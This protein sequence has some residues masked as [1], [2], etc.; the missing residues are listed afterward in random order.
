[1]TDTPLVL[2]A[3][4]PDA[5]HEQ[6]LALV[7]KTLKGKPFDK[8]MVDRTPEGIAIPGLHSKE[9]WDA[10]GDP[11]GLPGA[12]PF[13]RGGR[14]SG[15]AA[16]GWDI[17]Q[18]CAHPNPVTANKQ[19]LA[20]LETGATSV[21]LRLDLAGRTGLDSDAEGPLAGEDG[22]MVSS[23]EDL[24]T[25]LTG[26]YLDG[27]TVALEAGGGF[28]G[29]AAL[30][31]ALWRNK[32]IAPSAA[33]GAFNADPL[34]SL[35]LLGALPMTVD[36]ALERMAALAAH[37]AATYPQVTAVMVDTGAHHGAGATE[38]ED[39]A[40]MLATGVAYL[41]AMEQTGMDLGTAARQIVF[42]LPLDADQFPAIAKLRAARLL[43]G[44]VCAACGIEGADA[45]MRLTAY[46]S[47]R[48]LTRRDPWVNMLRT[49]VTCFAAAVGGADAV[50]TTP[51]DAALGVPTDFARRVARNVQVV[52][53]EESH[54]GKVIDPAGGSWYVETLT[55]KLAASAWTSF[56][57]IEA[58][59]GM[60]AALDSGMVQALVAKSREA[61]KATFAKRKTAVTGVS[62][63]PNIGE[64]PVETAPV[65][66]DALR[67]SAADRLGRTRPASLPGTVADCAG[68]VDQALKGA[69]LG[70]LTSVLS[71][72]TAATI[73][74]QPDYSFAEDYEALRDAA[75]AAAAQDG[76][77]PK[78]FLANL[79]PVA[80]HTARATFAKNLFEAGGVEAVFGEGTT[81]PAAL[82][83]AFKD[84][85]A[86]AAV[87]CSSDEVYAEHAIACA[88]ALGEAGAVKL[89]LA[90]R[91]ADS[92]AEAA[93]ADVGLETYIYTGCDVLAVLQDLH[94]VLGIDI[95]TEA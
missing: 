18:V 81:D 23:L 21:T 89:Y 48:I 47:P 53:M 76:V 92:A 20:D 45:A 52:L 17:R 3:E 26:V 83:A 64:S 39:L 82:A 24:E 1:M 77:R 69:S 71:D 79:G 80:V 88:K 93:Q 75:D 50:S 11:S 74:P 59:G 73:E 85:G 87:L 54:L 7:E 35:A 70:Q 66:L 38:S 16:T 51:F 25:V 43:W 49:T 68:A 60:A 36:K 2:A 37:T 57:A 58:A 46:P 8:A 86:K 9:D 42:A 91:A 15:N 6:W 14:A 28:D 90:G 31:Q 55:E 33:L 5:S 13:T 41:R 63:F 30:L 62:E 34:G 67:A 56:Q 12:A 4:F 19:I 32:G 65:D 10:T 29:A 44:K 40:C 61:R 84:S 94:A 78:V 27:A 72:G 22:I 95:G